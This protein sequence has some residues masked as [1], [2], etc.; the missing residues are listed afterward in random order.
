MAKRSPRPAHGKALCSPRILGGVILLL[1]ASGMGMFLYAANEHVR[2]PN[3]PTIPMPHKVWHEL[4]NRGLKTNAQDED[5]FS[6]AIA[7]I[8]S[9]IESRQFDLSAETLKHIKSEWKS[10]G[11]VLT[12]TCFVS[13]EKGRKKRARKAC[14]QALH[15]QFKMQDWKG[16]HLAYNAVSSVFERMEAPGAAIN[17]ARKAVSYAGNDATGVSF[18]MRLV[19]LLWK[20]GACADM[21]EVVA[22]LETAI[23]LNNPSFGQLLEQTLLIAQQTLRSMCSFFALPGYVQQA[24]QHPELLILS[25]V[26]PNNFHGKQFR[27]YL[28]LSRSG[29]FAPGSTSQSPGAPPKNMIDPLSMAPGMALPL[30]PN[31]HSWQPLPHSAFAAAQTAPAPK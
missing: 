14:R 23:K 30:Q 2:T 27:Q 11:E 29:H 24:I 9:Q 17:A 13:W 5:D 31:F 3:P 15:A 20:R 7:D 10:T 4:D 8:L 1:A 25:E 28:Q 12:L 26:D 6:S 18:Q 21:R 16:K 22:V 19:Q